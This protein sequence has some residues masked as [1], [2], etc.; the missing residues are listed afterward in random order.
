MGARA[1][2]NSE[3]QTVFDPA[4]NLRREALQRFVPPRCWLCF[5]CLAPRDLGAMFRTPALRARSRWE[6]ERKK[7]AN[8]KW[9]SLFFGAPAENRTPDTLIKSQVLY[10]LSY[11][12]IS[13]LIAII[14]SLNIIPQLITFVNSFSKFF[15]RF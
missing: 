6:Q 10:Q 11:R 3:Y 1:Q 8:T 7:I 2:K 14:S 13:F 9:Y 4:E 15:R 5:C 12:G